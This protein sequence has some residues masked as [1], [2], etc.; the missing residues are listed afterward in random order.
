MDKTVPFPL[1]ELE[2]QDIDTMDD[3]EIAEVKYRVMEKR[4]TAENSENRME[5]K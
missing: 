5:K 3:W 2:V 4:E 1:P